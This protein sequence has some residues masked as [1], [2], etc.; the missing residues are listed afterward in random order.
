M[1]Y[2]GQC[3]C[4]NVKFEV[5][6]T[7]E[8]LV[9]CNCSICKRKGHLLAFAPESNF[10]LLSG[11]ASLKDYQF[12]KKSIH[13]YFCSNCGVGCFGAGTSPDGSKSRAINVRCLDGVD[14]TKFPVHNYDGASL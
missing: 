8:T 9:A 7:I 6:M 11:E 2:T 4:G 1:T 13:H 12:G 14:F 3:H 10:K 5:E